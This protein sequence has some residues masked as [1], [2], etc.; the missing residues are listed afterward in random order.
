MGSTGIHSRCF[1]TL[2]QKLCFVVK[3]DLDKCFF[4]FALALSGKDSQDRTGREQDRENLQGRQ[5]RENRTG[6]T[7]QGGHVQ[8]GYD[9]Q[10][11]I[12]RSG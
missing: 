8:G 1:S 9:G 5:D 3:A 12:V 7:R 4:V 6:R 11:S 2:T 10:D